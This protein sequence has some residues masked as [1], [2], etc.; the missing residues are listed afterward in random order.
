MICS[1]SFFML[2]LCGMECK[3]G[4]NIGLFTD[5]NYNSKFSELI[6]NDVFDK[7]FA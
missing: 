7:N 4:F 6:I 5:E 3:P 2:N 1:S